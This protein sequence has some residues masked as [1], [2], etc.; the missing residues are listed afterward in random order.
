MKNF[1]YTSSLILIL[2]LVSLCFASSDIIV[3]DGDSLEIG[4]RKIRLVGIDAPEY[5]Q[6]CLDEKGEV[7]ACGEESGQ[8][9]Q[10]LIDDQTAQGFKIKCQ[11]QGVDRYKRQLCICKTASLNLNL[12][13]V[14]SGHAISYRSDMFQATEKRAKQAKKGVWQ[15]KFMRPE[16]FRALQRKEKNKKN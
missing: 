8:Y 2:S 7:Y 3:V 15:G 6:T 14:K 5:L 11:V 10:K 13:M 9:L 12:E 16:I 4:S 1:I